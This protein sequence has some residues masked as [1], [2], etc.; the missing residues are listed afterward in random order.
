[1]HKNHFPRR[2]NVTEK[3]TSVNRFRVSGPHATEFPR[4][5][6]FCFKHPNET[7]FDAIRRASSAA[8][9][10]PQFDEQGPI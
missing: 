4:Q 6:W 10:E 1:L 2:K 7:D 9:V 8:V 5:K 3:S